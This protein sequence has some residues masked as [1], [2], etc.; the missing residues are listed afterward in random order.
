MRETQKL[1]AILVA[2]AGEVTAHRR[3]GGD[4]GVLHGGSSPRFSE[5]YLLG[6]LRAQICAVV[7][8]QHAPVRG[9]ITSKSHRPL[10]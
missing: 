3:V 2:D 9:S 10:I 8:S 5:Y 7:F 1:A 6:K 4:G